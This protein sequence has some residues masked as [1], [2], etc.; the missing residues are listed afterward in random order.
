[1]PSQTFTPGTVVT[2]T[3]LQEVNDHVFEG[4][5]GGGGGGAS[6]AADISYRN[7]DFIPDN[8]TQ[9]LDTLLK[10]GA[11]S[12]WEYLS[13]AQ[14]TS[15]VAR[16]GAYDL[17]VP[18]NKWLEDLRGKTGVAPAGLYRCPGGL[19][20]D[21]RYPRHIVGSGWS[22]DN[23][24]DGTVF[25]FTSGTVNGIEVIYEY[26]QWAAGGGADA[27]TAYDVANAGTPLGNSDNAT[28]IEGIQLKGPGAGASTTTQSIQLYGVGAES[29]P[30]GNGIFMYWANAVEIRDCWV[31]GFPGQGVKAMF[32]FGSKITRG[33]YVGNGGG[34]VAVNTNNLF[35]MDGVKCIANG[36]K[37]GP[38]YNYNCLIG[39]ESSS[40]SNYPNLGVSITNKCDFE[41]GGSSALPGYSFSGAAST[42]TSINVSSGVATVVLSGTVNFAVGH[43]I[44]VIGGT[45]ANSNSAINTVLPAIIATKVGSTITFPTNAANGTYSTTGIIIGPYVVGLGLHNCYAAEVSAYVENCTGHGIYIDK[46][47][48]GVDTHT[49]HLNNCKVFIDSHYIATQASPNGGGTG[50]T[51]G[52][53]V[54]AV[55]GTL[56][57]GGSPATFTVAAPSGGVISVTITNAGQYLTPPTSP[58]SVTGGSG[59]GCTLSSNFFA[60]RPEGVVVRSCQFYGVGGG[61]YSNTEFIQTG[62]NSYIQ[63]GS[64]KPSL[65]LGP[66]ISSAH[67]NLN[68]SDVILSQGA[69]VAWRGIDQTLGPA[70][71]A[72]ITNWASGIN[73]LGQ[74]ESFASTSFSI[75][76]TA[77]GYQS[78]SGV[79]SGHRN[80]YF[81]S[82]TGQHT[83]GDAAGNSTHMTIIGYQDA[84]S[85][86]L[87]TPLTNFTGLGSGTQGYA[88][89]NTI[90]LGNGSVTAIKASVTSITTSDRRAKTDIADL[91]ADLGLEFV[92]KLRPVTYRR[93]VAEPNSAVEMGLIAQE[94]EEAAPIPLG[95]VDYDERHDTYGLRKDDL[96]A[97]LIKAVKELD[98]KIKAL[99]G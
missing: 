13:D 97:V 41:G 84:N 73:S 20:F 90:R 74:M 42:I 80:S 72:S 31:S 60:E 36:V 38:Y 39:V 79:K 89:S 91:S 7:S 27:H 86:P 66:I 44:G 98:D 25:E 9:D 10:G 63:S 5:D 32:C 82:N 18:V 16:D 6:T 23:F 40:P 47:C 88:E 24:V 19:R 30:T 4:D 8:T 58:F 53:V 15:V 50:Y 3:W 55:G 57:P 85:F 2:S 54:T 71:A 81:G 99:G 29:Q 67:S 64:E 61:V 70:R 75:Y 37:S 49:S 59:S 68:E 46:Y 92:R 34:V 76:N 1:M 78:G 52:D 33:Y 17:T 48:R 12:L 21:P 65:Y 96:I 95:M 62:Q 45:V 26:A 93:L 77:F 94:V 51:T 69:P 35:T 83:V 28:I 87:G 22:S 56:A 43:Y 11:I 14:I